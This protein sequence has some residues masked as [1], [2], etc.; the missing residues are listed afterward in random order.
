MATQRSPARSE[1]LG[2]NTFGQGSPEAYGVPLSQKRKGIRA[3]EANTDHDE[4]QTNSGEAWLPLF[5]VRMGSLCSTPDQLTR[6]RAL[7]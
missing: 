3:G 1:R 5:A 4:H 7:A 2:P 6:K